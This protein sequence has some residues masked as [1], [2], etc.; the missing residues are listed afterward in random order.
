MRRAPSLVALTFA[1]LACLVLGTSIALELRETVPDTAPRAA[2]ER[3][4][5]ERA[6][7]RRDRFTAQD[8][9]FDAA[10]SM[11]TL[12]HLPGDGFA[13]ALHELGRVLR[14]GGTVEIGVWGHTSNREWTS[15]DG[16]Y[17]NHRSDEQFQHE[18][19]ALGDVVA[20]DTW[21]WREDGGHYQWARVVTAG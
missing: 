6:D 5:A 18:L 21:D 7:E 1:L 17:F 9:S 2:I 15:P 3:A 16:R 12:M 8:R 11:S 4:A 20:F 10:W 19:H 14:P 13:L